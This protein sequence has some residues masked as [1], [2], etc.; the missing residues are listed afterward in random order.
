MGRARVPALVVGVMCAAVLSSACGPRQVE[1]HSTPSTTTSEASIRFTNNL[2]Q[3]V[4][5][6][7]NFS[8]QDTFLRQV[9]ANTSATIP[10][11]GFAPGASVTLKAVT[12]DG[13]R[14]YQRPNVVLSGTV[15][16]PLP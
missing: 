4:N 1:V 5:V 14:T 3:A 8:G 11:Q 12:V 16:F 7:V 9:A 10:I 13:V 6:Y 2:S 15:T